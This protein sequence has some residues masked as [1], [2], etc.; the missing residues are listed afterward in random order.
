MTASC[1]GSGLSICVP[2]ISEYMLVWNIWT[3][4]ILETSTAVMDKLGN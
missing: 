2:Y 3:L 1:H 4:E